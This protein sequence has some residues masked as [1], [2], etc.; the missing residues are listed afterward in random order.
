[1]DIQTA[2]QERDSV[3]ILLQAEKL[4]VDDLIGGSSLGSTAIIRI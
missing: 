4:P 3:I 2:I 1:M